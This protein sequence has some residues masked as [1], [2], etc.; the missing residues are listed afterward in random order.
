MKTFL[1]SYFGFNRQQRNGVLVL[2]CISLFLLVVRI[3]Y[4]YFI[5]PGDIV[6]HNLVVTAQ[7]TL[8]Q[9]DSTRIARTDANTATLEELVSIGFPEKTARTVIKYR[10]NHPFH[11]KQDLL[12]VYGVTEK[13]YSKVSDHI[14]VSKPG[15]KHHDQPLPERFK[16]DN[17]ERSPEKKAIVEL[18][19]ADSLQLESV[20]GIGP[21]YARR[22]IK[23]RE[24]LGGFIMPEQ[25]REVYGLNAES[26]A[27]I[28]PGISV[29]PSAIRKI[30]INSDEFKT[31][32]RHPYISYDLTKTIFNA[33]RK[34]PITAETLERIVNSDSLWQRLRPYVTY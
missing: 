3:V 16:K 28:R 14:T 13:L 17:T 34:N 26:Y 29:D 31:I 8:A 27:R 30:N 7:D 9:Q 25:L 23:Y 15:P 2:M 12:R 4:P 20:S 10:K 18:N 24:M 21:V 11:T 1:D 5:D 32:N 6:L 22:I 33:R 19:V